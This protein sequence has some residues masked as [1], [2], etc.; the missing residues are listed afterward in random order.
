[1]SAE[2]K[3]VYQPIKVTL[4]EEILKVL[5]FSGRFWKS[6][7]F[8]AFTWVENFL[9]QIRNTHF[10]EATEGLEF[11][12]AVNGDGYTLGSGILSLPTIGAQGS[13]DIEWQEGPWYSV[14]A[15]CSKAE[16]FLTISAKLVNPTRWT[17]AGHVIS[18]TQVQLPSRRDTVHH[19]IFHD[20]SF[21]QSRKLIMYVYIA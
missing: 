3:Y 21:V 10:F 11:S 9:Q 8:S 6:I 18:S 1:M 14:W 4:T 16:I 13:H 20:S 19:V 5:Q 17:E 2:V 12:W 7:W 15:S